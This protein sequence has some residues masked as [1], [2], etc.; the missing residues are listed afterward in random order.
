MDVRLRIA[1]ASEGLNVAVFCRE[2]GISRQTF[3]AW[4]RRYRAE[5]LDG[6]E[7]RSRAPTRPSSACSSQRSTTRSFARASSGAPM[8]VT[9]L[10]DVATMEIAAAQTG[11][12]RSARK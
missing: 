7:P 12:P 10:T 1:V 8:K 3:Y 2:H 5:G 11:M 6:L 9:A 4:R